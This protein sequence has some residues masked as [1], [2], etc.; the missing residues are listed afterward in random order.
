MACTR[1]GTEKNSGDEYIKTSFQN[2][3]TTMVAENFAC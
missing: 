3:A 1:R 2:V